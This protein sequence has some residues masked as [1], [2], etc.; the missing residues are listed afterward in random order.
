MPETLIALSLTE[1]E[2]ELLLEALAFLMEEASD[3]TGDDEIRLQDLMMRLETHSDQ[4]VESE[5]E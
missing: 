1:D 2:I 3:L 4:P 5:D